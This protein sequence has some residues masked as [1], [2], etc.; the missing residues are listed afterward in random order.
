MSEQPW[1]EFSRFLKRALE[2]LLDS[3]LHDVNDFFAPEA[4]FEFP[5]SPPGFPQRLEGSEAIRAHLAQLPSQI[6]I[7]EIGEPVVHCS[8]HPGVRILE[9]EV[10][11]QAVPSGRPYNQRYVNVITLRDGRIVRYL[12]YW[13]PLVVLEAMAS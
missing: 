11:G 4:V 10:R 2:G 12:D 6:V 3:E 5:F 8:E 13:N 9:Y 7:Q 1:A